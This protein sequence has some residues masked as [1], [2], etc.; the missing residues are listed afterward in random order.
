[1][2]LHVMCLEASSGLIAVGEDVTGC[3]LYL[4]HT[5]SPCHG[6]MLKKHRKA[7][8]KQNRNTPYLLTCPHPA[9]CGHLHLAALTGAL[10]C[11]CPSAGHQHCSPSFLAFPVVRVSTFGGVHF[12]NKMLKN[13][14]GE[15]SH[16]FGSCW[17]SRGES[18]GFSNKV[19]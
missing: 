15:E 12:V 5:V 8:E 17:V 9:V 6:R 16:E 7:V 3:G 4:C 18:C 14:E 10:Q 13:W 1:M 11:P 19:V 2:L